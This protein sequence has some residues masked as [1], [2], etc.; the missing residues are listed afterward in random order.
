M[1]HFCGSARLFGIDGNWRS[2]YNAESAIFA[3]SGLGIIVRG[4]NEKDFE[5]GSTVDFHRAPSIG[6]HDHH[7]G[8]GGCPSPRC[9]R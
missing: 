9:N 3:S 4:D 8:C 6:R 1:R 2:L 5:R 7:G